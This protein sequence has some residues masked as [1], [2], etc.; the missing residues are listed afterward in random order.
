M[1]E[2]LPRLPA[3]NVYASHFN[4]VLKSQYVILLATRYGT[5]LEGILSGENRHERHVKNCNARANHPHFEI[6]A[7]KPILLHRPRLDDKQPKAQLCRTF[8]ATKVLV[9]E[10]RTIGAR[11]NIALTF[12]MGD[13]R[14]ADKSPRSRFNRDKRTFRVT[15]SPKDT[16]TRAK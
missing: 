2:R 5:Y 16:N 3:R 10:G 9:Q 8:H 6:Q 13:P 4:G 11:W 14:A 15:T 7:A 1:I 12:E